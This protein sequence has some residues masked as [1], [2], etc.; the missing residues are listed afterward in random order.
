M[1]CTFV[2]LAYPTAMTLGDPPASSIV[3]LQSPMANL[4]SIAETLPNSPRNGSPSVPPA[5]TASRGSQHSH[6]P[7]SSG[8]FEYFLFYLESIFK[9]I[10]FYFKGSSS[11]RRSS[12]SRHVS[13]TTVTSTEAQQSNNNNNHNNNHNNNNT[14]SGSGANA[15]NTT[16]APVVLGQPVPNPNHDTNN[17]S[18]V[19]NPPPV[20]NPTLKC[21]LCQ[22]RLED[23]HFVQCPSVSH[24]KFCFPC[25]RD[26]IKRQASHNFKNLIILIRSIKNLLTINSFHFRAL[27]LKFIV[28]QMRN[29]LWQIQQFHGL[30]CKMRF[31]Q[32]L[33]KNLKLKKNVRPSFVYEYFCLLN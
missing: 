28:H 15:N 19:P 33:V 30:L 26:S 7:N 4:M 2:L 8:M 13:S 6:S 10:C 29:V 5:R 25:S 16:V 23:T 32:S 31:Q 18:T 9:L 3:P 11:G 17:V 12:G 14:A 22:E 1:F 24:H 27:V 20:S 21:T